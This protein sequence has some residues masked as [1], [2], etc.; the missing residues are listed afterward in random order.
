MALLERI[1]IDLD[2]S[3]GKP[4]IRELRYPVETVLEYEFM[5]DFNGNSGRLSRP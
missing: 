1:T 2:I 4:C 3:H 5:D